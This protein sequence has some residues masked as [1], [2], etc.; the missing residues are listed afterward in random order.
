MQ[1][2]RCRDRGEIEVV[3]ESRV[4]IASLRRLLGGPDH[5]AGEFGAKGIRAPGSRKNHVQQGNGQDGASSTGSFH[6]WHFHLTSLG[7]AEE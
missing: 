5:R 1:R 3:P 4:Q 2:R 6:N 7:Y